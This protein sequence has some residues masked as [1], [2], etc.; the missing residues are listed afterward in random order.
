MG[1]YLKPHVVAGCTLET[2]NPRVARAVSGERYQ[3]T[4]YTASNRT[5][6]FTSPEG[7]TAKAVFDSLDRPV[8]WEAPDAPPPVPSERC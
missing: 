4:V 7:R 1:Y 3:Q 5:A 6:V 2:A 8:R